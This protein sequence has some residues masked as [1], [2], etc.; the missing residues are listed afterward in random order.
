MGGDVY[1]A[2]AGHQHRHMERDLEYDQSYP[3]ERHDHWQPGIAPGDG[4]GG[5]GG[6]GGG[7]GETPPLRARKA[8]QLGLHVHVRTSRKPRPPAPRCA[9]DAAIQSYWEQTLAYADYLSSS[10]SDDEADDES[11]FADDEPDSLVGPFV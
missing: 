7:G 11:L 3:S 2:R 4:D 1:R 5:S 8:T 10:D 6:G 9:S